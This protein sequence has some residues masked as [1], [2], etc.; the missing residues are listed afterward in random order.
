MPLMQLL[1]STS[2]SQGFNLLFFGFGSKA[3]LLSELV[4]EQLTDG[5]VLQVNG[6]APAVSARQ[7]LLRASAVLRKTS[8]YQDR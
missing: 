5:G 7:V 1:T 3:D 2:H 8:V 4:K 6:L